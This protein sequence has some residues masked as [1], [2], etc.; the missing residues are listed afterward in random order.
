M[1]VKEEHSLAISMKHD[2]DARALENARWYINT[3]SREQSEEEFDLSGQREFN[4][5]VLADLGILTDRRDPKSLRILEIGC[6]VGR[7]T[8]YLAAVFGEVYATDVSGEMIR[9]ATRRLA[10]STNVT[11]Q[12]TNGETFPEFNDESFD[13]VF[14][15]YVFQHIP[16]PRMIESNIREG[17]RM[18]KPRGVFKFVT[19]GVHND[20]FRRMQKDTWTGASFPEA[21]IRRLASEL[22]A[23][24]L[25]VHGDGTQYCWSFFRKPSTNGTRRGLPVIERLGRAENLDNHNLSPRS[26][27]TAVAME[28]SGVDCN[29]ADINNTFVRLR[30]KRLIPYYCGP[31]SIDSNLILTGGSVPPDRDRIQ[32]SVMI[33][34]T[35][36]A[37]DADLCV[38]VSGYP[39][40]GTARL[41]LP[42]L[43]K[44]NPIIHLVL[45]PT[46]NST[47]L[48][49][50]V[51]RVLRVVFSH[52]D[53]QAAPEGV[54]FRINSLPADSSA[55]RYLP[56]NGLW[57]ALVDV[58][59]ELDEAMAVVE[60]EVGGL[61]SAVFPTTF[62][63]NEQ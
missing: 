46:D 29:T 11:F 35:E 61:N 42:E 33:P 7:I 27:D 60:V 9:Q 59:H 47:G 50:S 5:Q 18:L 20:D 32:V 52:G 26:G 54:V 62:S 30:E 53:G 36:P 6:G 13:V 31:A 2:W 3:L 22:G 49:R 1:S 48:V 12:E 19:N 51:D 21:S 24:L 41:V 15:A 63:R 23:Q 28:L 4:G 34:S 25:G 16:S 14:A 57:E 40:S 17:F 44:S 56:A 39:Q 10:A 58:P 8:K 43:S 38:E 55:P 45:D 37:G